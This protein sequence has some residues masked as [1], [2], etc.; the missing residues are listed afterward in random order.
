[1]SAVFRINI[2]TKQKLRIE[3]ARIEQVRKRK[4]N[5]I[6]FFSKTHPHQG[7]K[8]CTA[9]LAMETVFYHCRKDAAGSTTNT[10]GTR[11][12]RLQPT[13]PLRAI[14]GGFLLMHLL[15]YRGFNQRP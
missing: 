14:D 13:G 5:P 10:V 12:R 11:Q 2:A 7:H 3:I 8:Y 15:I 4:S 6:R 9:T 1:M